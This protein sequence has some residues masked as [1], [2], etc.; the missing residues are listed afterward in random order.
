MAKNER[1][2]PETSEV[3][4]EAEL[5]WKETY[6]DNKDLLDTSAVS[7]L[8]EA[9]RTGRDVNEI[10]AERHQAYWELREQYQA[11]VNEAR[12]NVTQLSLLR[13][14][15]L[16]STCSVFQRA[17]RILTNLPVEVHLSDE[18]GDG[19]PAWNDGKNVT[20]NSKAIKAITEETVLSLHGLNYHE[21]AHLFFTPRIGTALGK[22]VTERG[23]N[24]APVEPKR[25]VA[26]N[27]LEDCRAEFYVTTKYPSVRPFLIS[28]IG[29][30]LLQHSETFAD[31]FIL[32]AGRRYFPSAIRKASWISYANKHGEEQA[33][34]V[35]EIVSEYRTLV[36]P[37]DYT[38]GQELIEALLAI[39]PEQTPKTP[40]GC[41][42]RP[43]MRNGKPV[44]EREQDSIVT[45]D[46]EAGDDLDG[47]D[48]GGH[49]WGNEDGGEDKGNSDYENAQ[50]QES[51]SVD[52]AEQ[53]QRA[54]EN[55]K[56]DKSVSKKVFDTLRAIN[57]DGSTKTLL[58]KSNGNDYAPRQSE[59]VTARLFGQELERIRIDSDPAWLIEKPTGKLNVR[60]AMNAD[61]N[62]INKLFDRWELGNDD[63]DM[64]ACV[65][66]DRSG[67]MG[68]DIG[69]AC[70]SAW[71]I[72]RAIEKIDGRV[73]VLTF[74]TQSRQLYSA[75]EKAKPNAIKI[76]EANGGTDPEWA[77]KESERVLTQSRAKTKL[78][79]LLTDGGFSPRTDS[80]IERMKADG[81][82]TSLVY[83]TS[84]KQELE[85]VANDP[86]YVAQLAH[87]THNFQVITTPND[88]VKVAKSVVQYQLKGK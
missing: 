64:E 80:V 81:V 46:Q 78:L 26:F 3:F 18:Y 77:L 70:R 53:I 6:T 48:K 35:Y 51:E 15:S 73:T 37:R 30:Y 5:W 57:K 58:G 72:K 62:E 71:I 60:R 23:D 83:L 19:T 16:D 43:L 28:T 59:V 79:F 66:I 52:L 20:F 76:I 86:N 65:L 10:S 45:Q 50:F 33:K 61:V 39:L 63:Y 38:R 42:H 40:N 75:D 13:N 55:A 4:A 8:A 88:L 1:Y 2:L 14:N 25:A 85:R 69:S 11:R 41:G 29:D 47:K 12:E 21:V 27:I 74:A 49:R 84:W 44:S 9:T 32:L 24:N 31:Q 87:G 22:W 17:D 67:S 34:R 82:Y 56:K 7:V 36:Y 68:N 54:V